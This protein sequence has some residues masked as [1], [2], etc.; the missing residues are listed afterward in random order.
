MFSEAVG[1][2]TF[3]SVL[4]RVGLAECQDP[5]QCELTELCRLLGTLEANGALPEALEPSALRLTSP[6]KYNN[7]TQL[8]KSRYTFALPSSF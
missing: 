4:N 5:G 8:E 2:E 1:L 7:N 6:T 3:L